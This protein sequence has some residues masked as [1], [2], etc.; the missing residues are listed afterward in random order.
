MKAFL[1]MKRACFKWG[2]VCG[3]DDWGFAQFSSSLASASLL[4][5][6]ALHYTTDFIHSIQKNNHSSI[7]S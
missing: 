1:L 2:I 7:H 4:K 3:D 5:N 6:S